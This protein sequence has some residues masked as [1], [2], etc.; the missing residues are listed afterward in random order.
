MAFGNYRNSGI[1][2]FRD[3]GDALHKYENT[4]DIRGRVQEPKRPLGHRKAVDMYSIVKLDNG[5]IECVLYQTPVVT[6]RVDGTV[7][8]RA[9]GWASQTT[10]NFIPEVMGH[11]VSVRVFDRKLCLNIHG[12]EYFMDNHTAFHLRK[13][14]EGRWQP[15]EAKQMFV[16]NIK[17][18]ES[19]N[20]IRKYAE[21]FSYLESMRKLRHDGTNATFSKQE[22]EECFGEPKDNY[23][24]RLDI[25]L[26]GHHATGHKLY[27]DFK[28]WIDDK[29][30]DKHM[31]YYKVLL[32]LAN[33]VGYMDWHTNERRMQSRHWLEAKNALKNMIWGFYRDE[34]FTPI[35][36]H[37]GYVRRDTYGRF[38]EGEWAR[39]HE[40]KNQVIS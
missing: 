25:T 40:E 4:T 31:S 27:A 9:G 12:N 20:V 5:D 3:Y 30:E 16:H 35:A 18:K 33:T 22:I 19:N 37:K 32:V 10:A 11:G 2:W 6:F 36:V 38:F 7:S 14:E 1:S 8:L 39:Y 29:S 17:R 23:A 15:L 13:D 24:R 21:V 28:T 34:V 26:G